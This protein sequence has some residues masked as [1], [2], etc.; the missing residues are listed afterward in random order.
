ML[1]SIGEALFS[2]PV[3]LPYRSAGTLPHG[4][5]CAQ[6]FA[7]YHGSQY[8]MLLGVRG[9]GRRTQVSPVRRFLRA[10]PPSRRRSR[11]HNGRCCARRG[12]DGGHRLAPRRSLGIERCPFERPAFASCGAAGSAGVKHRGRVGPHATRFRSRGADLVH[13]AGHGHVSARGET[14]S[15]WMVLGAFSVGLR[16]QPNSGGVVISAAATLRDPWFRRCGSPDIIQ[17]RLQGWFLA[18]QAEIAP[19][20]AE[21]RLLYRAS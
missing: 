9:R 2:G 15:G 5:D 4:L 13:A 11:S 12:G 18:E 3:D 20:V 6:P 19:F 17:R 14:R 8:T 1:A 7:V 16:F 21:T 10:S